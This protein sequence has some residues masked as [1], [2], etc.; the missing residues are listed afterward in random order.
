MADK[1]IDLKKLSNDPNC[2][3]ADGYSLYIDEDIMNEEKKKNKKK[4]K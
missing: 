4:N 3:G 1:N 2:R